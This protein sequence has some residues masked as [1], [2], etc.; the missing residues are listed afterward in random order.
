[1]SVESNDI[2]LRAAERMR[3]FRKTRRITG[4]S[5]AAQ[6]T[7][8]G[9]P[10]SRSVLTNFETGRFKHVPV[11]LIVAAMKVLG[12]SFHQFM[13]GPLCGTCK[14]QPPTGFICQTCL[15]TDEEP[16]GVAA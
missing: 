3:A 14:D 13:V 12:V 7:R 4:E 11:D 2:S 16:G 15:R 5:F 1:M 9:Y 10:V 6:L 8:A